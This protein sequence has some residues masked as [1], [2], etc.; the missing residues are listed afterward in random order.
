[1]RDFCCYP[2]DGIALED[3]R[4]NAVKGASF[5]RM[6]VRYSPNERKMSP[7]MGPILSESPI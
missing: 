5:L 3:I 6:I 2:S 1:M 7:R 4:N